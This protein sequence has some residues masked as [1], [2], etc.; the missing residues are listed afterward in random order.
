M[1]GKISVFRSSKGEAE[2]FAAYNA[3]LKQWPVPYEEIYVPTSLGDTHVIAS[4]PRDG[5]PLLLFHPSGA[6]ATIWYRNVGQL[7]KH[8]RIYAVDT[9]GEPNKSILTRPISRS[10]Q[11]QQFAA[12]I[13][14]L[15]NGLQIDKAHLVGNSFGGFLVLNTVLHIPERIKKAVLISPAASFVQIWSWS[16]HFMPSIGIGRLTGSEWALLRPY[17]WI[18]QNFPVDDHIAKLRTLTA[19]EGRHRHWSPSVFNDEELRKIQ[20]PILLLIGD[21]EVIYNPETVMRKASRLVA[22]LKAEIISDANHNAE[23]TAPEAVNEKIISF[24]LDP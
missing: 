14:D 16:W 12:W 4:G 9:I 5:T 23:Y 17:N 11:R 15:L 19:L 24:L 3:I 20:T 2:Y 7:S 6:G 22:G 13:S 10:H 1:S 8:F 21:H 18:W